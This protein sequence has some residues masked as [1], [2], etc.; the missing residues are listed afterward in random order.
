MHK[1]ELGVREI[2]NRKKLGLC[3]FFF[4][5][6]TTTITKIQEKD[7]ECLNWVNEEEMK[8]EE[9]KGEYY[10]GCFRTSDWSES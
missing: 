6:T 3:L 5:M 10:E 2:Q 7:V 4:Q 8:K 9:R 1:V